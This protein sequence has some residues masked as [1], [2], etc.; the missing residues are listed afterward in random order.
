MHDERRRHRSGADGKKPEDQRH[1]STAAI[2]LFSD[3]HPVHAT[4]LVLNQ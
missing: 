3:H 2:H 4:A 1:L